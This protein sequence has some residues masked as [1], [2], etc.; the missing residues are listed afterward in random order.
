MESYLSHF[1]A[2][3]LWD[4]PYLHVVLG[5]HSSEQMLS[6][7]K[8]PVQRTCLN[9]AKRTRPSSIE[10]HYKVL[11]LP[12]EAVLIHKNELVASPELIFLDVAK[13]MDF[14]RAV[15]LGM[16]LCASDT[17]RRE[18]LTTKA[19]LESFLE[20]CRMHHGY[21]AALLATRYI[22]DNSWSVMESLLYLLL[23]LPNQY[24]GYG[25]KGAV[26]NHEIKMKRMKE[27]KQEERFIADL[28]WKEAKLVVEY[29]SYTFH[30]NSASWMKDSRRIATLERNGH[31]TLSIT[32]SQ[33][34]DD[35][36]FYEAALVISKLLKKRIS[37]RTSQ[38]E[39]QKRLLR[40]LLPKGA[41]KE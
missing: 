19:K 7:Q 5:Y 32:T 25:L 18:P 33:L 9:R 8:A 30:N 37:I 36:A 4:I 21:K 6:D 34:Y 11:P 35:Q 38:F 10:S 41:S 2:A 28:Y 29:D 40:K 23:T 15:L 17:T 26:L 39:D 31:K 14:H 12:S 13:D 3:R 16:Q 27:W 24:G 20:K 1:S 22:A